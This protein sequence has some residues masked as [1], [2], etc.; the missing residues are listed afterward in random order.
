M[1]QGLGPCETCGSS[2]RLFLG[3]GW[4]SKG[5]QKED[6]FSSSS[7][8][9]GRGSPKKGH[10]HI[11]AL[12]WTVVERSPNSY[13]HPEWAQATPDSKDGGRNEF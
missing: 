10:T 8:F 12:D 7:V 3:I 11:F 2:A 1:G 5:R 13:Y 4:V 6:H 9:W